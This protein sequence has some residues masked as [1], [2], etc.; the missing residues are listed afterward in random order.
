MFGLLS[1]RRRPKALRAFRPTL[2]ENPRVT[3]LEGRFL[4]A[5]TFSRRPDF[6]VMWVGASSN[7]SDQSSSQPIAAQNDTHAT[8]SSTVT[9]EV[10]DPPPLNFV[11]IVGTAKGT[12]SSELKGPGSGLPGDPNPTTSPNI[13]L[14]VSH[15]HEL[16]IKN[17]YPFQNSIGVSQTSS[18]GTNGEYFGYQVNVPNPGVSTV[19]M[20]FEAIWMDTGVVGSYSIPSLQLRSTWLNVDIDVSG[21]VAKNAAGAVIYSDP[22]FVT[23]GQSA[24]GFSLVIPNIPNGSNLDFKY[25]SDLVTATDSSWPWGPNASVTIKSTFDWSLKINVS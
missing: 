3:T 9:G 12:V 18:A 10:K 4:T 6:P 17:R 22:T 16:T 24:D 15:D 21:L 23:A 5:P 25:N 19:T 8:I 2:G 7:A 20:D 14:S 11:L 1:A 13:L